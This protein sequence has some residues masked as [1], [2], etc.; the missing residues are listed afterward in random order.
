MNWYRK[1]QQEESEDL[2]SDAVLDVSLKSSVEDYLT[3]YYGPRLWKF[4]LDN[5]EERDAKIEGLFRYIPSDLAAT[6]PPG[7]LAVAVMLYSCGAVGTSSRSPV[8][9]EW[10]KDK[11]FLGIM[12]A[13]VAG[14]DCM[15]SYL[16]SAAGF[17]A[18]ARKEGLNISVEELRRRLG[19]RG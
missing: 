5:K 8:G 11:K 19:I 10:L 13:F 16:S 4:A 7:E 9:T 17:Y 1:S 12:T 6:M 2:L 3:T 18:I 14:Y 15:C